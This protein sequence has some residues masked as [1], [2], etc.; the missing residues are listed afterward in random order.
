MY[1][2]YIYIYIYRCVYKGPPAYR[3]PRRAF[4]PGHTILHYTILYYNTIYYIILYYA[5]L[6][7]TILYAIKD[8]S[9]SNNPTG[10]P[11]RKL[12]VCYSYY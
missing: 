10:D 1:I 2:H 11:D 6:Y 12:V 4:H 5:M 3:A 8:P 7:Y 9:E